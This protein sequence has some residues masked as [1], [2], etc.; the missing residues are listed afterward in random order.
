MLTRGVNVLVT[1][2]TGL[3][4]GELLRAL[5]D[6]PIGKVWALARSRNQAG[7]A[8]RIADRLA[9]T[10]AGINPD[11]DHGVIPVAGD[12]SSERLGLSPMDYDEIRGEVDIIIHSAAE[13]SFIR[14]DSCSR[15]NVAGSKH[16]IDFGRACRR[17][18]LFVYISTAF[19]SGVMSNKLVHEDESLRPENEHHN[20]YTRSKSVAEQMVRDCGM[21][22]LIVRPSIVLSAGLSCLQFARAIL[23]F[24]PLLKELDALPVNPAGRPDVVPVSFVVDSIIGLL[25]RPKLKYDCYHI[26]ASHEGSG[27]YS[28]LSEVADRFYDREKPL[29]LIRP[30]EWTRE[31]H[32][33]VIRTPLQ[34]K[35]FSSLR[36]YLPFLNMNVLYDHSRL[37]EELGPRFPALPPFQSYFAEL[38]G[39][40]S[41]DPV[42]GRMLNAVRA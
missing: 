24:V 35:I 9:R 25:E 39:V 3:I 15:T 40:L 1:G 34:R 37:R 4:G 20:E 22:V 13:T 38:L 42:A 30:A 29:E 5:I 6:H 7:P 27:P 36:N 10:G 8:L 16:L 28:T 31:V 12:I 17:N 41:T 11:E 14:S 18:P 21:R 26:S 32:R 19:V 2:G 23:W 33:R